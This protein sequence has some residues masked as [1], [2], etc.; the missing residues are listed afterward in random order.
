MAL[1]FCF[2]L[3][4][5]YRELASLSLAFKI[6]IRTH[7]SNENEKNTL[8]FP[9]SVK[10]P[11]FVKVFVGEFLLWLISKIGNISISVLN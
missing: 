10:G 6:V 1:G 3:T 4:P 2:L 7:Q 11:L 8:L 9:S 5:C